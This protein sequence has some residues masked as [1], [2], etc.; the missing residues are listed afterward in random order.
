MISA[1]DSTMFTVADLKTQL[2]NL[3]ADEEDLFSVDI[4]RQRYLQD[5]IVI[6]ARNEAVPA[7]VKQNRL[8]NTL[9]YWKRIVSTTIEYRKTTWKV[10]IKTYPIYFTDN[11]NVWVQ[12][13]TLDKLVF[14]AKRF[15][16]SMKRA[17]REASCEHPISHYSLDA[18]CAD[19]EVWYQHRCNKCGGYLDPKTDLER[20]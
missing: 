5:Q 16:D 4:Q 6:Q 11:T 8:K 13:D 19:G 18:D 17:T 15:M 7:A 1:K 9:R 14:E 2:Y 3:V 12:T 10:T 20:Y